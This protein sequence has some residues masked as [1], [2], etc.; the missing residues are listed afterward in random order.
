MLSQSEAAL[1]MGFRAG[2][3]SLA[4]CW[5]PGVDSHPAVF[6]SA[7]YLQI[8][9]WEDADEPAQIHPS[10]SQSSISNEL[11]FYRL[12]TNQVSW[13]LE[14]IFHREDVLS[15]EQVARQAAA[16]TYLA[17]YITEVL[18]T[19]KSLL[20]YCCCGTLTHLL[21]SGCSQRLTDSE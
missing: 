14:C 2:P 1:W 15:S 10:C 21:Q 13:N 8:V 11:R 17:C 18:S 12:G 20:K 5:P 6:I 4:V 3:H 9:R 19:W 16:Q 7:F